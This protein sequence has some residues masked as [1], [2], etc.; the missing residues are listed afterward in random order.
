MLNAKGEVAGQGGRLQ[1]SSTF[2]PFPRKLI[3][4]AQVAGGTGKH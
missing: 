3:V 2:R 1:E 4:L